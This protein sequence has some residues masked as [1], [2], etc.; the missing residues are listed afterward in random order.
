MVSERFPGWAAL[1]LIRSMIAVRPGTAVDATTIMRAQ[2]RETAARRR[3]KAPR[4]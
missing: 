2:V 4:N 1:D 3:I